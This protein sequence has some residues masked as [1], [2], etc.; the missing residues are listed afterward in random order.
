[1]VAAV[2][3]SSWLSPAD[4]FGEA[5]KFAEAVGLRAWM[6]FGILL[7]AAVAYGLSRWRKTS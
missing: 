1:V 6:V 2:P 3:S 5:A 4:V 7:A